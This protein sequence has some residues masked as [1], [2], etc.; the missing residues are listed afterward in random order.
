MSQPESTP[1][2]KQPLDKDGFPPCVMTVDELCADLK[3]KFAHED[4]RIIAFR[5]RAYCPGGTLTLKRGEMTGD[6]ANKVQA[7]AVK[8][9]LDTSRFNGATGQWESAP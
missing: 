8:A 6:R 7:A 9:T 2:R 4:L 5:I 3:E 1:I